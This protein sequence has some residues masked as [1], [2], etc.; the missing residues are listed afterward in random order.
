MK[1]RSHLE[2]GILGCRRSC[3][4]WIRAFK[5]LPHNMFA[6]RNVA[7]DVMGVVKVVILFEHTVMVDVHVCHATITVRAENTYRRDVGL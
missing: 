5:W 3:G 1:K 7:D 4:F 2:K 6:E